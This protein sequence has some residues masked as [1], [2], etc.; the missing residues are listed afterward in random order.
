VRQVLLPA[1]R[2]GQGRVP[3]RHRRGAGPARPDHLPADAPDG[4]RRPPGAPGADRGG[5]AV[6]RL[7]GRQADDA[8]RRPHPPGGHE[9][10]AQGLPAGGGRR[11]RGPPPAGGAG[12]GGRARTREA[13]P[14]RKERAMNV[15]DKVAVVT[16][17]GSGIGLAVATELAE[18]GV[19]AVGMVDRSESVL[20]AAR[21]INDTCDE[22]VGDAFIGDVTDE[23]FRRHVFDTL[24]ARY[25]TPT[26]CIPAAG[27]TRD[28]LAVKIDKETGRSDIYPTDLF[29]LVTEVNLI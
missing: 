9:Q 23:A 15:Q 24:Q 6:R 29:R 2:A 28:R 4:Q 16:G 7:D 10:G 11:G 27:I 1:Q 14:N 13:P 18:R 25:G 20:R 21:A 19:R 17:A 26:I 3:D 12:T 8:R 22:P 5:P